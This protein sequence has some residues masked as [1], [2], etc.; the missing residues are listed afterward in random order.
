MS[1]KVISKKAIAPLSL[2]AAFDTFP[3]PKGAAIHIREFSQTLFELLSPG[4]LLALGNQELPAWQIEQ[5]RQ[6]R[7]LVSTEPNFLKRTLEF[8]N[9]VA[10]QLAVIGKTLKIAHFR[11]P[12]SG[13]PIVTFPGRKFKTVFEINALPS[14]ELPARYPGLSHETLKKI[15]TL[16]MKCIEGADLIVCPS[17]TIKSFLENELK[18]TKPIKV[19]ANGSDLPAQIPKKPDNAP[20]DYL[21]YLGAV[22]PWQGIEVLFKALQFLADFDELKLVMC[23]SGSKPRLKYLFKLAQ[24]LNVSEKIIWNCN[25]KQSEVHKWLAHA[26]ISL[27]P[28]TECARNLIQGCCPIKIIESMAF[29]VPVIASDIPV[30][31]ELLNH[32]ENGRLVRPDRP[33]ELARSIRILL[34]H[35]EEAAKL[36]AAGREKVIDQLTWEHSRDKLRQ[37][38]SELGV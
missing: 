9:F 27:A 30:V 26:K 29:A 32:N 12:W 8:Q 15:R 11:D 16:E 7:R 35:P 4:L 21:I 36:G 17:Q 25:L 31:R 28:L 10:D 34:S 19:I 37:A 18:T 6:I 2:Y 13:L 23:A 3:A 38:Y 24:H 22:Q 33:A 14:I 20:A 1:K 5:D